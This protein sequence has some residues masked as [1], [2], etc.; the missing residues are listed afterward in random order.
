MI[1]I[2]SLPFKPRERSY[3]EL[4]IHMYGDACGYVNY[5]NQ[6]IDPYMRMRLR[7][8]IVCYMTYIMDFYLKSALKYTD[9]SGPLLFYTYDTFISKEIKMSG[10]VSG[11]VRSG[12]DNLTRISAMHISTQLNFGW[13]TVWV[14]NNCM[15]AWTVGSACLLNVYTMN[16]LCK[17]SNF[18]EVIIF[19]L[20]IKYCIFYTANIM[21]PWPG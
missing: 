13:I 6:M 18:T 11:K 7:F 12:V 19:F 1:P 16:S 2:F 17:R 10:K 15:Y 14:C 9:K 8:R 3:C 4:G 5:Q 21:V 20:Q